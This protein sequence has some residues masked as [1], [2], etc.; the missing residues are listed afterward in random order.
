MTVLYPS[1]LDWWKKL[2]YQSEAYQAEK[3]RVLDTTVAQ[4]ESVLPGIATQVEVSDVATP[5]T[6]FRYTNNW[7]AALGFMMTKR[8][9]GEMVMQPQYTLPGLDCFYM[10]G[11]WVK[12][13]GVPM[14]AASG[15][16]VVQ[17]MCRRAGRRFVAG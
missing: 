7:K 14:A 4:L 11:M 15:R 3:R 8:L 5:A 16:E 13:F 2:G 17:M 6:T 10:I 1:E 12:G 9:A